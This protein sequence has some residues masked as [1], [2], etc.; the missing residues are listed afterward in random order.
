MTCFG[1]RHAGAWVFQARLPPRQSTSRQ[2]QCNHMQSAAK[3]LLLNCAGK[4]NHPQPLYSPLENLWP[5]NL[6]NLR[7]SNPH[8]NRRRIWTHARKSRCKKLHTGAMALPHYA[9]H[10]PPLLPTGSF[11]LAASASK[12][13][14]LPRLLTLTHAHMSCSCMDIKKHALCPQ[15]G[16][17]RVSLQSRRQ[18]SLHH[19]PPAS[20]LHHTPCPLQPP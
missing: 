11:K 8:K 6:Q 18:H 20:T 17:R 2:R 13:S 9:Q 16:T 4:T 14:P 3:W 15:P 19:H 10:D 5:S 7:P 12:Q 1:R